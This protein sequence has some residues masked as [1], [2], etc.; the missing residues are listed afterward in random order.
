MTTTVSFPAPTPIPAIVSAEDKVNIFE[1]WQKGIGESF[2]YKYWN[3]VQNHTGPTK[4]D[5]ADPTIHNSPLALVAW[6]FNDCLV[7]I[8]Y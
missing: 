5:S 2:M 8:L 1:I 4:L 7:S 6:Q 3:E